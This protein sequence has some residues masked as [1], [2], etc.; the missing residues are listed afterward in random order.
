[1]SASKSTPPRSGPR[2]LVIGAG[3]AGATAAVRLA[4]R[5]RGR[6]SVTV[7]NPRPAFVNRLRLHHVAVGRQVAAPSLRDLLGA[8]VTFV[9]GHVTAL[10]PDAGLATVA[11]PG[12]VRAVSFDRVWRRWPS[13]LR[14]AGTCGCG[15]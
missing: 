5:S 12:G 2:V 14:A 9:E 1:M 8:G 10:D 13:W 3:Y 15:W 4:G 11:G 6:V 7:V